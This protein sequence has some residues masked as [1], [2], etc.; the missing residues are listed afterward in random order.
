M[1]LDTRVLL[2]SWT[3]PVELH[4]WFNKEVLRVADREPIF[5][6]TPTSIRNQLGQGFDAIFDVDWNEDRK[7]YDWLP[8][9]GI[10]LEAAR[11]WNVTEAEARADYERDVK[12]YSAWP[13]G[14][15][16]ISWDTAYGYRG[17]NGEGC[18]E[19]HAKFITRLAAEFLAPRGI[20]FHWQNEFTGE[21]NE[22]LSGL[23]EFAGDG[24]AA[25]SWFRDSVLPAVLAE[26]LRRQEKDRE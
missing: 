24:I 19:L 10:S 8:Y 18:S 1:T 9:H 22:G 7:P 21:W 4:T 3:D 2:H 26:S 25:R 23:T 14:V 20:G 5:L 15:I 6:T 16:M 17:E 13:T 12:R 11:G